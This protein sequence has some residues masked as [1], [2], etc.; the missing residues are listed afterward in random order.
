MRN[1]GET[2]NLDTDFWE[3]AVAMADATCWRKTEPPTIHVTTARMTIKQANRDKASSTVPTWTKRKFKTKGRLSDVFAKRMS[4]ETVA[5]QRVIEA[6]VALL[7]E[8]FSTIALFDAYVTEQALNYMS[9]TGADDEEAVGGKRVSRKKRRKSL[10]ETKRKK[11]AL[12]PQVLAGRLW[13]IVDSSIRPFLNDKIL[14]HEQA[15]RLGALVDRKAYLHCLDKDFP[16]I[17]DVPPP[18]PPSTTSAY[19]R[20][21]FKELSDLTNTQLLTLHDRIIWVQRCLEEVIKSEGSVSLM[22]CCRATHVKF[23]SL[24]GPPPPSPSSLAGYVSTFVKSD[25]KFAVSTSS[26]RHSVYSVF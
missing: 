21:A 16:S 1:A 24:Y 15:K 19:I 18:P 17:V 11:I 7:V 12:P 4:L 2:G 25:F 13:N 5:D 22:E 14:L 26:P 10:L 9:D 6:L 8:N 3:K 20:P 23:L